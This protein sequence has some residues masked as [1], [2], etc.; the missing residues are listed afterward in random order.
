MVSN[1]LAKI[2][3]YVFI[4]LG[5]MTVATISYAQTSPGQPAN[6]VKPAAANAGEVKVEKP[7]TTA[8]SYLLAADPG[9]A[10]KIG[11]RDATARGPATALYAQR[12]K[13]SGSGSEWE[14]AFAPYLFA[15]G[16]T[17]NIGARGRVANIDLSFS[18]I[19]HHLDIGLMGVFEARKGK[20]L[21]ANDLM[22]VKLSEERNTP[23]ALFNTTRAGVNLVVWNPQAG[24]RLVDSERGSFDLLGGLRLYSVEN[25]LEFTTGLLPGFNASE[26]KTWAAPVVGGH[27]L[28]NL[29]PRFFLSTVFDIGGG[30]GTHVTGQ[31]YGGAGFKIKP[32]I[33]LLGGYRY[34][35]TDYS[36]GTFIFDTSMSGL[37]FGA[38]FKF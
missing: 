2:Y 3:G 16:L 19:F 5:I 28:V 6:T 37:L 14:F 22:W 21:I 23:G 32:R 20:L 15:T 11:S 38:K 34:L 9:F 7:D 27:G 17:G 13:K 29:T 35:K 18:D 30:F 26:R 12:Q 4:P 33:A 10:E 25:T 1:L 36:S 24:I 8:G 31:F